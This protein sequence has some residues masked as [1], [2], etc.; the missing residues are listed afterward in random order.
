MIRRTFLG[1][2]F[3]I[4]PAFVAGAEPFDA[5]A[6]VRQTGNELAKI[7]N[8]PGSIADKRAQLQPFID[9][10]ADV[11]NVARFCLGRYWRQATPAQQR[12][13]LHLFHAILMRNILSRISEE[14]GQAGV[15]VT[16]NRAEPREDGYY[17]ATVIERPDNPPANVTW[18]VAD[19]NGTPKI[20]DVIA[21]GT[22]L[23]LTQR[24]DYASFLAH[25]GGNIDALIA[26]LREQAEAGKSS[27]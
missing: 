10:V 18:V 16:I 19:E 17:V 22:S 8:Q 4:V 7:V 11:D 14:R 25:N 20:I 3:A 15:H 9:R 27:G 12:E 13:Y 5:A 26:A 24:S 21:E 23:R 1:F 2:L 6:F